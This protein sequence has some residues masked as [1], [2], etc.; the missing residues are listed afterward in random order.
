MRELNIAI[1]PQDA[2]FLDYLKSNL[3]LPKIK[4][5]SAIC[6]LNNMAVFSIAT[7]DEEFEQVESKLKQLLSDLILFIYKE[8]FLMENINFTQMQTPFQPALLKALVLFDSETDKLYIQSKLN[9]NKDVYLD[10]FF[11]F[12]LQPLKNRWQEYVEL[13]NENTNML[14]SEAFLD[15]LKFLIATIKPK[16]KQVNVYFNGHQFEFKD[17]NLKTIPSNFSAPD[18]DEATLITT[19]I[20]LAPSVINLHCISTLSNNTFKILYYIFDKRINLL[21]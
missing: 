15:L 19:L 13:T 16:T 17:K 21:V 8:R 6:Q 11:N 3:N 18:D 14:Q 1:N 10:S 5:Y 7:K 20:T 2:R 4:I 9:L 12:Q